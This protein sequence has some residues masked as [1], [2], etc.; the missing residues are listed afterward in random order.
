MSPFALKTLFSLESNPHISQRAHK[1]QACSHSRNVDP[2][3]LCRTKFRHLKSLK[4]YMEPK[5]FYFLYTTH[6]I[7]MANEWTTRVAIAGIDALIH[8]A[9][10]EH[11]LRHGAAIDMFLSANFIGQNWQLSSA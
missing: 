9:S 1:R 7:V 11:T 4:F 10:A 6:T 3:K 2:K 8:I 5:T